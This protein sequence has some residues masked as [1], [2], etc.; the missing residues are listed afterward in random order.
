MLCVGQLGGEARVVL[1]VAGQGAQVE[2]GAADVVGGLVVA[3]LGEGGHGDDGGVLE[4][5]QL[6]GAPGH[7]L[8]E[9]GV[10]VAQEVAGGL[11]R[12]W[13]RIRASTSGGLIGLVM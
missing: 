12:R 7:L 13:L 5:G 2:L 3:G 8:L 10:A 4:Q 9:E 1:Q 11:E 6:A